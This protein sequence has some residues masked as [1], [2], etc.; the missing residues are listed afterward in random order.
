MKRLTLLVTFF[1]PL[2]AL[3]SFLSESSNWP[4][5]Q[6]PEKFVQKFLQNSRHLWKFKIV[7]PEVY[8]KLGT[9]KKIG[10]LCYKCICGK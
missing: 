6:L 2:V 10:K 4:K 5:A 7:C 1:L 8:G 9:C 3:L